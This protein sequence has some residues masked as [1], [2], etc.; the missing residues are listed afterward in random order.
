[1]KMSH[2]VI[3][4]DD[5]TK[6]LNSQEYNALSEVLCK[7]NQGRSL[8]KRPTDHRYIIV[9]MDEPF[10]DEVI[11]VLEKHGHWGDGTSEFTHAEIQAALKEANEEIVNMQNERR[12]AALHEIVEIT[13]SLTEFNSTYE[14]INKIARK[15]LEI[16]I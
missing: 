13:K 11:S 10:V 1:M 16:P 14:K 7:I 6:Y 5:L 15:G 9:N 4:K 8:D 3:K 2:I 12:H